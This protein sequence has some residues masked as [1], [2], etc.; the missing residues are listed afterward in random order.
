VVLSQKPTPK[1]KPNIV[2]SLQGIK[3]KKT[4]APV[5]EERKM[6][7]DLAGMMTS[8]KLLNKSSVT[9][10]KRQQYDE[11]VYVPFIQQSMTIQ[12][13]LQTS[14][15]KEFVI[16]V[17]SPP[18]QMQQTMAKWK[19]MDEFSTESLSESD[20]G[21]C[22]RKISPYRAAAVQYGISVAEPYQTKRGSMEFRVD[23]E[24]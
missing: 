17:N 6:N 2:S 18:K 11:S 15:K 1:D 7:R 3:L 8:R 9:Q 22:I 14:G 19:T 10:L 23:T 20:F 24:L 4:N 13:K 5:I 21:L 12:G 16:K